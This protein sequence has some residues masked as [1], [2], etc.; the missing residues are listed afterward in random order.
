[1]YYVTFMPIL[2]YIIQLIIRFIVNTRPYK[3]ML[4]SLTSGFI[5]NL[6]QI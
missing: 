4:V 5:I 1:M 6:L 3:R 2:E